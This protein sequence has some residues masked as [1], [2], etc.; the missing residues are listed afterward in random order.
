MNR[1]FST[2]A[3]AC[4]IF[5][6]MASP[7][8]RGQWK[9]V[10][11][12]DG[13]T[14]RVEARGDENMHYWQSA[15]GRCYVP[16][17]DADNYREV[18]PEALRRD[19]AAPATRS[20]KVR[21][22]KSQ[23]L[24]K[25]PMRSNRLN[26]KKHGLV[27]LVDFS[28]KTFSTPNPH[29]L[30]TQIFNTKGYREHGFNGSV[31][32]YF[33]AQSHG[34]F[35]ITFDVVGPVT[36][37]R[38]FSY[39]GRN[40]DDKVGEMVH[41]ACM[42][43]DGEVDFSKYD[44]DGDGEVDV[45]YIVYAGY[46][47]AD[48]EDNDNY[49]WPHMYFLSAY[50]YYENTVL[51]L[52]NTVVDVYACSN[53]MGWNGE[54]NGIGTICHEYSHCLG[55]PDLYDTGGTGNFGMGSWDLMDYGCYNDNGRTPSG[56]TGYEKMALGWS[57]PVELTEPVAV[58]AMQPVSRMGWSYVVYNPAK[59]N[60]FC[61]LDNR[62]PEGFD[63][64]LPGHGMI[65]THVDYDET[66]WDNNIVNATGYDSYSGF[67]NSHQRVTIY[68]ADNDDGI[69]TEYADAYPYHGNDSLTGSSRPAAKWY[70]VGSDG[71]TRPGFSIFDIKEN[72][73]GTMSFNFRAVNV[74]G[75]GPEVP[76]ASDDEVLLR[77]TFDRCQGSGGNDGKFKGN[78]AQAPIQTD[79]D[80]W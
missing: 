10:T 60:E 9:T 61:V 14:V 43:V 39:Y 74:P 76:P 53:E 11:L 58:T 51:K 6:V 8:R 17:G 66:I 59:R 47:Q 71:E 46:G 23:A 57:M 36:M 68:H 30:Y 1:L 40:N 24:R 72:G 78:I 56:Y 55:L 13:S 15:D 67:T 25:S 73:D 64:A 44:W 19:A 65:I 29:E 32:D 12:T 35:D 28:G 80:G 18:S 70:N 38:P 4:T 79:L 42:A 50:S 49:I 22:L 5:V 63:A 20:S 69:E 75:P 52:D 26:G 45:V 54:L 2:I 21:K 7:V 41:D 62:Q 31:H 48:Y 3:L 27:I 34:K 37:P 16:D 77:E 33:L